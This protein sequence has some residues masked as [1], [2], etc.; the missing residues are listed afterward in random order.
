MKKVFPIPSNPRWCIYLDEKNKPTGEMGHI[1]EG[2][3]IGYAVVGMFH[4][5][6]K[7]SAWHMEE[8]THCKEEMPDDTKPTLRF[9][10]L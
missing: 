3:K 2:F 6:G 4:M 7:K 8:C 10:T 9:I 5:E 1:C